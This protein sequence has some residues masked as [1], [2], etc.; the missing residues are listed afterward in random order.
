M[1]PATSRHGGENSP[2]P[3]KLQD[4]YIALIAPEE[5]ILLT[6][7]EYHVYQLRAT[8]LNGDNRGLEV[9]LHTKF[10]CSMVDSLDGTVSPL[11]RVSGRLVRVP[12]PFIPCF[13]ASEAHDLLDCLQ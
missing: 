11:L 8:I 6:D 12:V 9:I 1:S 2:G 10:E 3:N 7:N 13:I 5:S 4:V